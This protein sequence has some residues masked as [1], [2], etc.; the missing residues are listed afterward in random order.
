MPN[1]RTPRALVLAV[2]IAALASGCAGTQFARLNNAQRIPAGGPGPNPAGMPLQMMA[3]A[4]W[5]QAS[6]THLE[7]VCDARSKKVQAEPLKDAKRVVEQW[8]EFV[9]AHPKKPVNNGGITLGQVTG[10]A[11]PTGRRIDSLNVTCDPAAPFVLEV[12]G[13]K[14]TF[15]MLWAVSS[16]GTRAS[17]QALSLRE[18]ILVF[19]E[20]TVPTTPKGE[21]QE[22][23]LA[24]NISNYIPD[25]AQ[26]PIVRNAT[27]AQGSVMFES[28]VVGK[29]T[30]EGFYWLAPRSSDFG[31]DRFAEAGRFKVGD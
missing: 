11:P 28:L 21:P 24:A 9:K 25:N 20:V 29:G 18:N 7:P 15:D 3:T 6:K 16:V 23:V 22:V 19:A 2:S 4:E 17:F 27:Q 31:A 30:T 14:H 1:A 13:V 8:A 26:D 5:A 10:I 12:N